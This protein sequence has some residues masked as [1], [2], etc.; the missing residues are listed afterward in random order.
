MKPQTYE[1][2][3]I[4]RM[5]NDLLIKDKWSRTYIKPLKQTK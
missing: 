4:S 1:E 5:V 3:Q 2:K